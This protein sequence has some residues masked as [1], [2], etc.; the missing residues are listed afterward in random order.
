MRKRAGLVA[1][2]M[3]VGSVGTA[4]P[5]GAAPKPREHFTALAVDFG[6]AR[7]PGGTRTGTVDIAIDRWSTDE[8]RDRLAAALKEGGTDGLLN[9][10]R[11]IDEGVG[12]INTPGSLG[13]PLRFARRVPLP[14]GGARVLL[15]TD[16][17]ISFLEIWNQPDFVNFPF[18]V[19]DLRLNA[20]GEGEGKLLPLARVSLSP[21]HVVEVENYDAVPVRLT[22]VRR[23]SD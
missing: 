18:M 4:I 9:A 6:G 13:Y 2:W 5:S 12:R 16:R 14:E 21:D 8:E 17:P 10:L 20:N 19:I 1:A 11:K 22:A 15:A 23:L 3:V 7:R